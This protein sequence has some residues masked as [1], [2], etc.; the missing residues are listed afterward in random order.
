MRGQRGDYNAW[1]DVL[2][3]NSDRIGWSWKDVGKL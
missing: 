3:G 2:R 1:D